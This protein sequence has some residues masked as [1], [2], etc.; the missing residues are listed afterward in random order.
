MAKKKRQPTLQEEIID[1]C[2]RRGIIF[3]SAEIYGGSAGFF[4]FGPVGE[5]IRKNIVDLW[6]EM[7]IRSEDNVY[8]ISGSTVLPE[9]VFNASG[10]TDSFNDPMWI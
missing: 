7:F 8:Q 5:A 6:E 4:E 10:H 3:P 1:V 2:L 9:K